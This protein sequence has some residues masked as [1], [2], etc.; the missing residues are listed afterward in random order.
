MCVKMNQNYDINTVYVLLIY[1][2]GL[3]YK[4]EDQF[5]LMILLLC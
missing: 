2:S 5:N 4:D 1:I 3:I